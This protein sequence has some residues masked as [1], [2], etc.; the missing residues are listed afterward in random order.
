MNIGLPELIMMLVWWVIPGVIGL[1]LVYW[2]VRMA[3]RHE[4]RAMQREVAQ[5]PPL[6]RRM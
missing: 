2:T 1:I 3:I 6:D 4:R 5:Q